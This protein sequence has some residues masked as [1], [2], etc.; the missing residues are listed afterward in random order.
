MPE[1]LSIHEV[2]LGN[3]PILNCTLEYETKDKSY[4]LYSAKAVNGFCAVGL[5]FVS[6]ESS[7]RDMWTDATTEVRILFVAA[8]YFDGVRH[9]EIN[10]ASKNF[11]GYIYY[12]KMQNLIELF[13]KVRELELEICPHATKGS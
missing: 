4:R 5:D 3:R 8:A 2:K 9:L 12:P 6:C 13:Q 11:A 7:A 1:T 10:T